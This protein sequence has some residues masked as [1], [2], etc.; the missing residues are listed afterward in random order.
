MQPLM[1]NKMV[2]PLIIFQM[3]QILAAEVNL[4]T[5]SG[6]TYNYL[7]PIGVTIQIMPAVNGFLFSFHMIAD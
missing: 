5:V 1:W 2:L 6:V 7:Q 4:S 3:Y